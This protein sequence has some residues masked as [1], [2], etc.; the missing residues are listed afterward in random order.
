[1]R[2][3][4]NTSYNLPSNFQCA[5]WLDFPISK[6]ATNRTVSVGGQQNSAGRTVAGSGS[7][8]SSRRESEDS[9]EDVPGQSMTLRDLRVI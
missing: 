6:I 8:Q 7:F 9:I 4:N 3:I 5:L 1:M 2:L